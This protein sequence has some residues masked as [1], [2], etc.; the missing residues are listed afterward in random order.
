MTKIR[1]FRAWRYSPKQ[2]G[3]FSKV[4]APPYDVIEADQLARLYQ[5]SPYNVTHV[6][7]PQAK[8]EASKYETAKQYFASWK[9]SG[10]LLQD[11]RPSVYPYFQS[12]TLP[13]GEKRTRKG[14]F[15]R[16]RLESFAEG[17]IRPHEKTFA[18][19]KE[20]RLQLMQATHAD[21]SPI[22]GLYGDPKNAVGAQLDA[23]ARPDPLLA[24]AGEGGEEHRLWKVDDPAAIE[25][26]LQSV[27]DRPLLIADGHHRYE[28]A[29]NYLELHKSALGAS[30]TGEEGF[31]DVMMYFC[32]IQ[33]PGL[34]ILPTHRV[35]AERLSKDVHLTRNL[36][37]RYATSKEFSVEN[38]REALRYLQEEGR[39]EHVL[40]WIHDAVIEV[41]RFDSDKILES[42]VLNH[43]HY[44]VRDLDVTLLHDLVLEEVMGMPKGAQRE[45]GHIHYVKDAEEAV[46]L[47]REKNTEGFLLNP[48]KV[49]QLEAVTEI[50]AT[51]PQKSTFF[52]PKLLTGLVF[53]DLG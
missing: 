38:H 50:G 36:L 20:D 42:Q 51:M 52:Y 29:L 33:D 1:P 11:E 34:V 39:H 8:G 16:R 41:L 18:G 43:L 24:I 23:L 48:T 6:D 26:L 13:T 49:S 21:L 28:T 15:A 2:V 17:G 53:Y 4:V 37:K 47:T 40:G 35:L 27:H 32:S 19:P 22:F 45:Y 30:Y 7:L 14:F 44:A 31:N 25:A 5:S 12:Y 10:I 9:Q 3:D 46:R